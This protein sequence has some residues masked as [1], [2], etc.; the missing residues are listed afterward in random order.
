M[1]LPSVRVEW[2]EDEAGEGRNTMITIVHGKTLYQYLNLSRAEAERRFQLSMAARLP[3]QAE[4]EPA[5]AVGLMTRFDDEM[6]LWLNPEEEIE[7]FM[8]ALGLAPKGVR[9]RGH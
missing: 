7:S 3:P 1:Q 8:K 6:I 4:I 9:A 2:P 5:D